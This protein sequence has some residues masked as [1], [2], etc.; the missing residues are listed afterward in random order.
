[1]IHLIWEQLAEWKDAARVDEDLDLLDRA[2]RRYG[3][4][5]PDDLLLRFKLRRTQE[6]DERWNEIR[7]NDVLD[8]DRFAGRDV[9]EDATRFVARVRLTVGEKW[10][11]V[12]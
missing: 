1:M 7:V 9:P 4:K 11:Q 2:T 8:V 5:G 6:L 3:T 12:R 10:E